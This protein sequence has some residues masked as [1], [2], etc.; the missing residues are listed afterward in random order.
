MTTIRANAKKRIDFSLPKMVQNEDAFLW[1]VINALGLERICNFNLGSSTWTL[2][3]GGQDKAVTVDNLLE[4]LKNELSAN[5]IIDPY[6]P[7]LA[8]RLNKGSYLPRLL[9]G[10]LARKFRSI[11]IW[12]KETKTDLNKLSLEETLEQSKDYTTNAARKGKEDSDANPVVYTFANGHK[13]VELKTEEALKR[14]GDVMKHCVGNYCDA[15]KVGE[16]V[17]Y[18]LRTPDNKPLVTIEYNTEDEAIKQVFGPANADPVPEAKVLTLEFLKK[19]FPKDIEFIFKMGGTVGDTDIDV[20]NVESLPRKTR[21]ALARSRQTPAPLLEKLASDQDIVVRLRVA[22]NSGAPPALLEKLSL[23]DDYDADTREAVAD[24]TSC[25][26]PVLERLAKDPDYEV[27]RAVARN[28]TTPDSILEDLTDDEHK[29]VRVT[30][31]RNN[32]KAL[33]DSILEK[34]ARDDNSFVRI[35]VAERR[36]TP[37]HILTMLEQDTDT[38][39]SFAAD[40]GLQRI[41]DNESEKLTASH[42]MEI[43]LSLRAAA[44]ALSAAKR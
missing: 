5:S 38:M 14:E 19:K 34:L 12:A 27:R 22:S 3:A 21:Q 36:G 8:T 37:K 16:S 30:I 2:K 4:G 42:R 15:V 17:I 35:G 23:S 39:V 25:P 29:L 6:I 10:D 44:N 32:A 33:P 24:N 20:S 26:V 13:V 41:S 28:H 31:A 43:A 7:W 1:I 40:R 9:F 18:S 11:C